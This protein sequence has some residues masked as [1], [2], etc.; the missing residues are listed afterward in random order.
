[1]K[2][3]IESN[4]LNK[5]S[6]NI[7]LQLRK[8]SIASTKASNYLD[9]AN[10]LEEFIN[11]NIDLIRHNLTLSSIPLVD[12]IYPFYNTWKSDI[13]DEISNRD[14]IDY[15]DSMDD[16]EYDNDEYFDEIEEF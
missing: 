5:D 12:I 2:Y 13:K 3:I 6:N 1:M 15:R 8:L 9:A 14:N 11:N 16:S 4:K 7:L 10:M